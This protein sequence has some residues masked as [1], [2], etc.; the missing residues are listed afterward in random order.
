MIDRLI[1]LERDK[2]EP[3]EIPRDVDLQ[4][5][6]TLS[7]VAKYVG[8]GLQDALAR[9]D[10]AQRGGSVAA[11]DFGG[12]VPRRRGPATEERNA[13]L[14]RV[15][16]RERT[17]TPKKFGVHDL[18]LVSTQTLVRTRCRDGPPPEPT[19]FL[20]LPAPPSEIRE[21]VYR[22]LLV[23][24]RPVA[25]R[26]GGATVY[27]RQRPALDIAILLTSKVCA[28]A[29]RVHYAE[30]YF[31]YLIRDS[32]RAGP[33]DD[34]PALAIEEDSDGEYDDAAPD[35]KQ[36]DDTDIIIRR[37]GP[38]MRRIGLRAE[39][40]RSG[41]EHLR[42]AARAITTF[43]TL[44]PVRAN[45]HTLRISIQTAWQ[46]DTGDFAFAGWFAPKTPLMNALL[47]T[48]PCQFIEVTI[49]MPAGREAVV[50]V[51]RRYEARIRRARRGVEGF[52]LRDEV[53]RRV[54]EEGAAREFAVLMGVGAR[55]AEEGAKDRG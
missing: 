13:V 53:E 21:F 36:P 25:V 16:A 5:R 40:N 38:M 37:N 23:S 35:E 34:V 27:R 15:R 54:R 39:A 19:N 18:M 44:H 49:G 52:V 24:P 50:R 47:E 55:I 48:L 20:D 43:A 2:G 45:V 12:G 46:R 6:Y 3:R 31:E 17:E 14:E 28:E 32:T 33:E 26:D 30:N 9:R 42:T 22:H 41:A 10:E 29:K 51:D 7:N 1:A 4:C 8:P 11:S